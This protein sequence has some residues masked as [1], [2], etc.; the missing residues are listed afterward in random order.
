[1]NVATLVRWN[2]VDIFKR[3]VPSVYADSKRSPR[4]IIWYPKKGAKNYIRYDLFCVHLNT[5]DP[6][7]PLLGIY[8]KKSKTL[9]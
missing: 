1:M 7:I 2:N 3:S 6:A 5:I 9:I 8:L 4:Y